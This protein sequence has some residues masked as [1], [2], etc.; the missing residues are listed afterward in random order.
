MGYTG[1]V[2]VATTRR[3]Q[4]TR[5]AARLLLSSSYVFLA[6]VFGSSILEPYFDL[7]LGKVEIACQLFAFAAY[8][9]AV[10]LEDLL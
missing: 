6:L 2:V 4:M 10:L 8:H 7:R 1:C 5:V 3:G 9:I